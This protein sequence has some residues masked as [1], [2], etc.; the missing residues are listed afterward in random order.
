MEK[1]EREEIM[2]NAR[3]RA[4]SPCMLVH[5]FIQDGVWRCMRMCA[6]DAHH[7]STTIKVTVLGGYALI[8]YERDISRGSQSCAKVVCFTTRNELEMKFLHGRIKLFERV[9]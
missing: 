3:D 8:N 6:V 2:H 9:I 5:Y 7:V 4:R 1:V